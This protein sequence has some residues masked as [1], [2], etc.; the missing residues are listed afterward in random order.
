MITGS[1]IDHSTGVAVL[2]SGAIINMNYAAASKD[3]K[4]APTKVYRPAQDENGKV[5]G[6]VAAWGENNLYPQSRMELI[7]KDTELPSLLDFKAR[8]LVGKGVMVFKHAGYTDDGQELLV[9]A[10]NDNEDAMAFLMK[11]ST[12]RWLR[13]ASVDLNH[14]FNIFPEFITSLRHNIITDIY[15]QEATDCRWEEMDESGVIRQCWINADWENYKS[16]YTVV[17]PVIEKDAPDVMARMKAAAPRENHNF[18]YPVSYPTPGRKY[19]QLPHHDGFFESGWYDVAQ[20]IPE[21]KKY[22]MQNQMQI[23]YHVEIDEA[24]WEKRYPGF[25]EKPVDEQKQLMNTELQRFNDFL[26]G[27]KKAG[28]TLMSFMNWDKDAQSHRGYWKITEL[29]DQQKDGKYIEDSREASMHKLRALGLDPTIAGM[30]P[31]R[32]NASAGSGSDKWAAIKMYL[33]GLHAMRE[34]L[35]EPLEFIFEYNGWKEQGLVPRF[36]DHPFFFTTTA[37][38]K[39]LLNDNPNPKP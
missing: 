22:L 25:F 20:A 34:T 6:V 14:F 7:E 8:M 5:Q 31:G 9:P 1:H 36:V 10:P 12:K 30:G 37:S 19:Y 2:D 28:K 23:K 39:P 15:H 33:A 18:I 17:R 21:F 11:R 32:D 26:T 24:W 3:R 16:R 13:E 29:K 38:E 4:D 27:A 35:L